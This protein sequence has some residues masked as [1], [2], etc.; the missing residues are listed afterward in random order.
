M[1]WEDTH[2]T[3]KLTNHGHVRVGDIGEA[4][5]ADGAVRD[6]WC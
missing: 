3:F 6:A 2:G 1:D 5:A 4:A